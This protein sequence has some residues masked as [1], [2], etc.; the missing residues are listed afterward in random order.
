MKLKVE[1]VN[2]ELKITVNIII[3]MIKITS[4]LNVICKIQIIFTI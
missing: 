1:F 2:Y 3:I 4:E